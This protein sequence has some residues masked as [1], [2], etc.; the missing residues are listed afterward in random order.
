MTSNWVEIRFD[1]LPL[2]SVTVLS[3]PADASPKYQAK[4]RRIE[5]AIERHGRHNTY[6]LHNATCVF[7]LTNLA[8]V[9]MVEFSLEGTLFTDTEDRQTVR[10][11]LD[12]SMSR[13]TCDWLTEPVVAWFADSVSRAISVEFDRFIAAGDLERTRKRLESLQATTDS[14]GGFV[15]MYL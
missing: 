15:G 13:E 2:R 14:S 10:C 7:H 1:C 3:V 6:Y 9:G 4:C 11:D 12:V 5:Q 8:S